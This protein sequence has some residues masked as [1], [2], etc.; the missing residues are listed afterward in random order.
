MKFY[1]TYWTLG[2]WCLGA[3]LAVNLPLMAQKKSLP[4]ARAPDGPGAP[5]FQ[6]A[7]MET[8]GGVLRGAPGTNPPVGAMGDWLIGPEY[9]PAPEL[10]VVRGVPQGRIVEFVM[11]SVDSA[12]YP[13][14]A[15][16]VFG[17]V[18]PE[19]PQT[20]IGETQ[21]QPY[22]RL[23]TV[24][25]PDQ[26]EPGTEIPFVVH[27]DGPK[28]P[29][30]GADHMLPRVLNNLIHQQRV[31][32]MVAI[33]I[34]NGGGDAQGS[35]RGLEYDTMSGKLAEFI[36]AE[37]LPRVEREAGVWLADDPEGRAVMGNSSGGSAAFT[38]AWYHPEWYRRVL[39][40]SG[41]YVN[42]QWPFDA[43]TPG[44]AWEYH[45]TLIPQS[46]RK[47]IRLWMHVSDRDNFNP[48]IMR[49]GMHDWVAANHRMAAVLQ[50]K[51][52]PYLYVFS[53]DS[54]HGDRRVREQT[55]PSALEW[56]WRGY[57][58]AE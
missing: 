7:G 41:T 31:P 26:Y 1:P 54:R 17:T 43:A 23:I 13:G 5:V 19:N 47:P 51:E 38:M 45:E 27:H 35:Q 29:G 22:T 16:E 8:G 48:N 18:D 11:N 34:A 46:P 28:H 55:L 20:L 6:V 52:Y 21:A 32:P 49:D 57:A 2:C 36:Q 53:L 9:V 56:L 42:Q 25:V 33:L 15:R 30:S 24:Y 10:E 37:V 39:T 14:I 50:A 4:A 12:F 40:Y 58:V 3:L 44:G